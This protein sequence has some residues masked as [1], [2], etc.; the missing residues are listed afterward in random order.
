MTRINSGIPPK[1]LVDKHL[2][3]EY[4]EIGRIGT[5]L[6]NKI[7]K[8]LPFNIPEKFCLGSGHMSFFLNKGKFIENRFEQIKL[9]MIKRGYQ[10]NLSFRNSWAKC[11]RLDMYNDYQPTEDAIKQ[12]KERIKIRTPKNA[13][14]YGKVKS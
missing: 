12:L 7:I 4:R 14:Y 9:E 13:R 5:L 10:P 8:N 11:N 1:E 2:V 6:E 3:A